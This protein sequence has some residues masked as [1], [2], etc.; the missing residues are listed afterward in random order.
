M[1][2]PPEIGPKAELG[3]PDSAQDVISSCS[4]SFRLGQL[5]VPI[6]PLGGTSR[7]RAE[8][9]QTKALGTAISGYLNSCFEA[10]RSG[11]T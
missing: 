2:R 7:F 3:F 9:P 5:R 8:N 4:I 11:L 10:S 1:T 6:R